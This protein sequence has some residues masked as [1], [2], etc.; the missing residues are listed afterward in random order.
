MLAALLVWTACSRQLGAS[1]FSDNS[2]GKLPFD[3]L[4]DVAGISPTA[5]F[6]PEE[7]PAGTLLNIRLQ[8]PLSSA[9]AQGGESFSA[10]VEEPVTVGGK[11]AVPRG[12]LVTGSVMVAKA[13]REPHDP[14]YLRLTLTSILVNGKTFSLRTSSIFAKGASYGTLATMDP[15]LLN[16][17]DSGTSVSPAR[18]DVR[19]STGHHLTFRLAQPFHLPS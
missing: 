5:R 8:T 4:S 19:F 13:S 18:D 16:S 14:G 10:T 3:R 7:I 11:T 15:S 17:G 9:S 12:A 1:G 2:K 6:E